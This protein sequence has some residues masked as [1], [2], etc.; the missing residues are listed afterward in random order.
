MKHRSQ[1][2]TCTK[3]FAKRGKYTEGQIC[4]EHCYFKKRKLK[5]D[6]RKGKNK[7]RFRKQFRKKTSINTSNALFFIYLWLLPKKKEKKKSF[8]KAT[9][10]FLQEMQLYGHRL[11]R[12]EEKRAPCRTSRTW[13]WFTVARVSDVSACNIPSQ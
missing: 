4:C 6:F 2:W 7:Y 3:A 1:S 11:Y 8:E 10:K 5:K 12:N 9:Y 13:A